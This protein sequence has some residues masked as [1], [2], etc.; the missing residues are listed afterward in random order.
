[1]QERGV[2]LLHTRRQGKEGERLQE[3]KAFMGEQSIFGAL[4]RCQV[5]R[6]LHPLSFLFLPQHNSGVLLLPV[7]V[8]HT[9]LA[10]VNRPFGHVSSRWLA[11]VLF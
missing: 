3:A 2:L 5:L 10:L 8:L 9:L 11:M 1:M 4:C 6:W 7:A